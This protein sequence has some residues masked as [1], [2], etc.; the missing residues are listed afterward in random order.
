MSRKSKVKFP[1]AKVAAADTGNAMFPH[2]EAILKGLPKKAVLD[3]AP[4]VGKSGSGARDEGEAE[5]KA[6]SMY[7]QLPAKFKSKGNKVKTKA[8]IRELIGVLE[9]DEFTL[10]DFAYLTTLYKRLR[11]GA[12]DFSKPLVDMNARYESLYKK[13]VPSEG[14]AK[15]FEGEVLRACSKLGYRWNNDGDRFY[16]GYGCETAGPAATF[17]WGSGIPGMKELINDAARQLARRCP[18]REIDR[19]YDTFINTVIAKVVVWIESKNGKY[20]KNEGDYLQTLSRWSTVNEEDDGV[21][22][23]DDY[24][25]EVEDEEAEENREQARRIE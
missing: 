20:T 12:R 25:G 11:D 24:C 2:Q 14:P 13:M 22:E 6:G 8:L 18:E 4:G 10:N 17:L 3:I 16:T 7:S 5:P 1:A 15:T 23:D 21:E 19:T 9:R